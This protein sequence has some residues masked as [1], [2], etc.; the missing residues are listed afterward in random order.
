MSIF[1]KQNPLV[2]KP[3]DDRQWVGD[4]FA[5]A[6]P[7]STNNI[8]VVIDGIIGLILNGKELFNAFFM[9]DFNN[10]ISSKEVI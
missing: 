1:L 4:G 2:P 7:I 3:F 5:W 9:K 6:C 10:A 8:F